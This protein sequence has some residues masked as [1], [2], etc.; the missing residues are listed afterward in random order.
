[1]HF[2]A[3]VNKTFS[4]IFQIRREAVKPTRLQASYMSKIVVTIFWCSNVLQKHAIFIVAMMVR[5]LVNYSKG[6]TTTNHI[7]RLN[8]L[9]VECPVPRSELA[10]LGL[11]EGRK[12]GEEN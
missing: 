3:L 9:Y 10:P 4:G 7:P 1:M 11:T 5:I 2:T 8:Q 6:I 12:Q